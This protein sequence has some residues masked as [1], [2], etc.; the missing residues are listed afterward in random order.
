M[1]AMKP[2]FFFAVSRRV[3]FICKVTSTLSV[4]GTGARLHYGK[5]VLWA[6]IPGANHRCVLIHDNLRKG[7]GVFVC[8][9]YMLINDGWC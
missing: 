9:D 5:G 1:N 3:L 6:P 2:F 8:Y 4:N 7:L